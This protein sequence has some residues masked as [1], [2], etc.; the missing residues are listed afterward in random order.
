MLSNPLAIGQTSAPV[1]GHF[2]CAGW[3]R[4]IQ[5]GV[6]DLA[7]KGTT[8]ICVSAESIKRVACSWDSGIFFENL[9]P[10]KACVS[11]EDIT[12][13]AKQIQGS[14]SSTRQSKG[15]VNGFI[16]IVGLGNANVQIKASD[17]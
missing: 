8:S 9:N 14:C 10:Y 13:L 7:N 6:Q 5:E 2:C 17:C 11:Y 3:D 12:K 15:W 1:C 16:K 4:A